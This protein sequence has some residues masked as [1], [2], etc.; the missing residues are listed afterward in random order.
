[1]KTCK[2]CGCQFRPVHPGRVFCSTR[3]YLAANRQMTLAR[4][5]AAHPL[6]SQVCKSCGKSFRTRFKRLTCSMPCRRAAHRA[7]PK[8]CAVCLKLFKPKTSAKTCSPKCAKVFLHRRELR[9]RARYQPR[10]LI[11]RI[12]P[13]C[14]KP[15]VRRANARF[16]SSECWHK[17]QSRKPK[18]EE[19]K[20]RERLRDRSRTRKPRTP[21]QREREQERRRQVRAVY[22]AA[23]ELGLITLE[24]FQ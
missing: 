15:F 16:C 12:C 6:R 21:K 24:D 3:C 1:M 10:P 19:Q 18:T 8:E 2:G 14:D 7:P 9:R 20:M 11:A 23:I 22:R 5:H 4:Y 17:S 13:R